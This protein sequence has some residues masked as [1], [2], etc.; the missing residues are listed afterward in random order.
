MKLLFKLT[1]LFFTGRSCDKCS[2]GYFNLDPMN[3][4]GCEPCNCDPTGSSNSS[5]HPFTGQCYCAE[6]AIGLKCDQCSEGHFSESVG[7]ILC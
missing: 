7:L 3:Q 2:E 4:D 6:H 5:C 1:V